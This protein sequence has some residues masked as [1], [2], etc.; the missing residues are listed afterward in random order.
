MSIYEDYDVEYTMYSV[1]MHD[2]D[3]HNVGMH[4]VDVPNLGMA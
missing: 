4:N 2:V 3:V 1:G